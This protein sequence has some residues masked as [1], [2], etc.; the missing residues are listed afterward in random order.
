MTSLKPLLSKFKHDVDVR[1]DSTLMTDFTSYVI[2][3]LDCDL[4][5]GIGNKI[6]LNVMEKLQHDLALRLDYLCSNTSTASDEIL[7]NFK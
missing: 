5:Y 3:R 1:S 7:F 6:Y 2:L 4:R